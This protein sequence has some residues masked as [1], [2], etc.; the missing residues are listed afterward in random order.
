MTTTVGGKIAGMERD[1]VA[2]VA[3]F[4]KVG[5]YREG[6]QMQGLLQQVGAVRISME[7][8]K[9]ADQEFPAKA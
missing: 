1:C 7:Q 3:H 9:A 5:S 8:N 6:S 4:N 2:L